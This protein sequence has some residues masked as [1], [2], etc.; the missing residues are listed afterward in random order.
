MNSQSQHHKKADEWK[1]KKK[2]DNKRL[3][4]NTF[5]KKGKSY[6]PFGFT[7]LFLRV[8]TLNFLVE[9]GCLIMKA[10][11]LLLYVNDF[12]L[13]GLNQLIK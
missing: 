7:S 8:H 13:Y 1:K 2:L 11:K 4:D 10:S 6:T 3:Y 5:W 12:Y 9:S